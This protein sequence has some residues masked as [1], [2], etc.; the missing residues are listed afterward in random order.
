MSRAIVA[1]S[2]AEAEYEEAILYLG[3]NVSEGAAA[4]FEAAIRTAMDRIAETPEL[5]PV[6]HGASCYTMTSHSIRSTTDTPTPKSAYTLSRTIEDGPVTGRSGWAARRGGVG[7][8][9][10]AFNT[11]EKDQLGLR[12]SNLD[13]AQQVYLVLQEAALAPA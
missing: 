9:H 10:G 4:N 6:K 11:A 8:F 7:S 13:S 3:M 12:P 5:F 2:S 1:D